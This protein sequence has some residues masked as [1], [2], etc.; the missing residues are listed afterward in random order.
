MDY[1]LLYFSS[2]DDYNARDKY[3]L[4]MEGAR[5]A[6]KNDF[7]AVWTPERHFHQF[8]GLFPNPAVTGAA[9]AAVTNRVQVRAGSVVLPLHDVV[10]VAEEWS[11]IDNLSNG[12]VGVAFA[13]GW[14]ADDFVLAPA[15]YR[16]RREVTFRAIQTFRRLWQGETLTLQNGN[17]KEVEVKI[18][19]KPV[20]DL[21]PIWIT[22]AGTGDTFVRAGRMGFNV[23]THLLGQTIEEVADKVL[24]YREARTVAG[25]DPESGKV[26]LMLHTFIGPDKGK[27]KDTVRIPFTQYLRSSVD[28]IMNLV[29]TL[30][31]PPDLKQLNARE[32]DG[33]LAHAFDRYFDTG[34]LF[35]NVQTCAEMIDRLKGIGV[36][37][38]ACLIDFGIENETVLASLSH[39][40]DLQTFT[41]A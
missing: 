26:T 32:M 17:G 40:K 29:R 31:L 19:P 20:Q 33:L 8:G 28:L 11:V 18:F 13:S 35:G 1:S 30:N 34:A 37:E 23:L 9:I 12:R 22:A 14:H 7:T 6:D 2:P 24:R 10:R 5:F 16:E 27:V 39:I 38:V 3:R 25:F 36:N 15:N 41:E 4:L 21:P